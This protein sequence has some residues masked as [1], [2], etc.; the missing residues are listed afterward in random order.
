MNEPYYV[1]SDYLRERYGEKVYRIPINL[2]LTCPNR[3]GRIGVGGCSFCA[4]IGAGFESL[5]SAK[6]VREQLEENITYIGKKYKAKKFIAYFQN[7]TNTYVEQSAFE[8][9]I[10][11]A[12]REDVVEIAIA[13]RPDCVTDEQLEFLTEI[14]HYYDIEINLELGLQTVNYRTLE[15]INRGHGLAEFIDCVNRC[16]QRGFLVTVHM[17]LNLPTDDLGDVIEGAKVLSALR[18]DGVKLHSLYVPKGSLMAKEFEEG[19]Y[20]AGTVDDYVQR[21]ALFLSFLSPD[22]SIQRVVGRAPK[23]DVLDCNFN[24]SWWR[25]K[26]EIVKYMEEHQ[27]R[28][29]CNCNYLGGKIRR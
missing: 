9:Y 2:P 8:A 19:R 10:R 13:T 4:D 27:L 16:K 26:D 25:I 24:M 6:S 3:D 22:I 21:A 7:Y 1:Y 20:T 12:I 23:E 11:E 14:K 17:I 18:I 29:G 28:Q 15:K 5:D